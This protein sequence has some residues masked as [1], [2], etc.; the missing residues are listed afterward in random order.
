MATVN[1][2]SAAGSNGTAT[3][4]VAVR[5]N[6]EI[7]LAMTVLD[8]EWRMLRLAY[9]AGRVSEAAFAAAVLRLSDRELALCAAAAQDMR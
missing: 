7:V 2:V 9:G 1:R 4:G 3:E 5:G 8:G 6:P